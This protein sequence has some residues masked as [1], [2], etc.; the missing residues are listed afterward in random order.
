VRRR[1]RTLRE[2]SS[3]AFWRSE[4]T[5]RGEKPQ[6]PQ[7]LFGAG[8]ASDFAFSSWFAFSGS[9]SVSFSSLGECLF[10]SSISQFLKMDALFKHSEPTGGFQL[11]AVQV[12]NGKRPGDRPPPF[13]LLAK[14]C[15][16]IQSNLKIKSEGR[17]RFNRCEQFPVHI[18]S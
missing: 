6:P 9:C 17:C 16:W 5:E 1:R 8:A 2:I 3:A 15:H 13:L 10:S 18:L 14:S 12:G 11:G 4:R 7:P